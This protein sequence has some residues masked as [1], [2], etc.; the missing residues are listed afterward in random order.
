MP[1]EPIETRARLYYI[2]A[3]RALACL[4]VIAIHISAGYVIKDF[5]SFDFWVGNGWDSVARI[6]VPLFVMLSG[7]LMLDEG[8]SYSK[9]KLIGHIVKL[10]LFF[11]FWSATYCFIFQVA[12]PIAKGDALN[13]KYILSTLVYGHVHLWFIYM[14]IGLYAL[15][16]LLRL[17]VCR[18]N[19]RYVE[20]FLILALVFTFA[21][22][23][24]AKAGSV[25]F[26]ILEYVQTTTDKFYLNYVGGFTAYFIL[27]WYL[28]TYD[29]SQKRLLYALG[30]IGLAIT[31]IGTYFLSSVSNSAIQMYEHLYLNVFFQSAAIFVFVKS[32]FLEFEPSN[33]IAWRLTAALS[34]YSLGIYAIHAGIIVVIS[35]L[36]VK[37]CPFGAIVCVP[38]EFVL[39]A[40][41][42]LG[43]TFLMSKIPLLKKV[44]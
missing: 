22:P 23:Q 41:I 2:D 34:K 39:V 6:G 10:C 8:Y 26:P 21:L 15:V 9:K 35:K 28:R 33:G 43:L 37:I 31:F 40:S 13:F 19:K 27:G 25:F 20:Y 32:A 30:V 14:I 29:F 38:I 3:L 36:V 42:S 16:P 44:V 5:G 12:Q 11:V 17:W 18:A 7:A 24:M 1:I 4:C